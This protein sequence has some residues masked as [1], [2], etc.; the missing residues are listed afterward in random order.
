MSHFVSKDKNHTNYNEISFD[1]FA[2]LP[3]PMSTKEIDY[4]KNLQKKWNKL[5]AICSK[6]FD[7][8]YNSLKE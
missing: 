7:L 5:L 2:M 4:A 8:L 1:Q 6:D 3:S